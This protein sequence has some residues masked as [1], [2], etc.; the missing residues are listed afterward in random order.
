M[1]ISI[2][3]IHNKKS[4]K[5]EYSKIIKILSSKCVLYEKN[6]Y[7]YFDFINTYLFHSWN[8]RG[9]Y[10]DCNSYL[11]S[12]GIYLSNSRKIHEESFLNFLEFLLNI[13]LL[14]E[15]MKKY[16]SVLFSDK[17][18]SILFHNVPLLIEDLGY[19]PY[20]IDDKVYLLPKDVFYEDLLEFVPDSLS[21][22]LITYRLIQ[23]NGIK[24]KRI[25]LAKLFPMI[26]EYKSYNPSI[27]SSIKLIITKMGII[28]DIDKKYKSLST[29]KLKK[30]YDYCFEMICY[31]IKSEKVMKY[32]EEIRGE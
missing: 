32:R 21:E 26:E 20:T 7:S 15:S 8:Y 14:M 24:M 27:Y 2:F 31:L 3:Q 10:L 28:G 18:N 6:S 30:Y 23:N 29:Y 9:T 11:E 19:S 16:K 22:L 5:E 1:R 25:I 4:F 12:I 13:Q 17:A